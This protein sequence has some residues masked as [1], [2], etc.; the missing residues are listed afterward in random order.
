MTEVRVRPDLRRHRLRHAVRGRDAAE[1]WPALKRGA[2]LSPPRSSRRRWIC[3]WRPCSLRADLSFDEASRIERCCAATRSRA[4]WPDDAPN[5]RG[6]RRWRVS[7]A[8]SGSTAGSSSTS[9]S[10]MSSTAAV[11]EVRRLLDAAKA[12]HG[13]TL[14][15]L[16]TGL[17]PIALG[18]ATKTVPY[19]MDGSKTYRFT[20]RWGEARDTDDAEGEVI[21]HQ[22]GAAEPRRDPGGACRASPARS[23]SARPPFPRSRSRASAPMTWPAPASAPELAAAA[24]RDRALRAD[25]QPDPDH[26]DFEAVRARAP[27]CAASPA[28]WPRRSARC[29]HVS[30]L[31]RPA[32]G[33]FTRSQAISLDC[34]RPWGIVRPLQ[35]IFSGRDRAGR[36]PGAGRDRR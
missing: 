13:G 21:A 6:R 11:G 10:G 15:P 31:R 8:A 2:G 4:I 30:A 29:G 18:E 17:L 36:H 24:G 16:A 32:V 22:R 27:I 33:P 26:A 12:G 7:G 20:L 19:V 9:R 34:W 1:I 5:R 28:T 14:D 25:R 35:G 3:A 23:S